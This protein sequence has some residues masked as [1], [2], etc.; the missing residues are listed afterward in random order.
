[1]HFIKYLNNLS[2]SPLAVPAVHRASRVTVTVRRT[3]INRKMLTFFLW[4]RDTMGVR[5]AVP[6]HAVEISPAA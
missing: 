6:Q 2:A 1:M 5:F 3:L 4:G